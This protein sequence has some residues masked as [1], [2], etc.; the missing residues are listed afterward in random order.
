MYDLCCPSHVSYLQNDHSCQADQPVQEATAK[1]RIE[2]LAL[3][4]AEERI[5]KAK[6][7]FTQ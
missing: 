6:A 1:A 3:I 2:A 4:D 5:A 7:V